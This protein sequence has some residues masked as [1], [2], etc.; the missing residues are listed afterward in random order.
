VHRVYSAVL[1]IWLSASVAV[2]QPPTIGNCTVFPAD[3]I[4]NTPVDQLPVSPTSSTYINTI[5]SKVG[6]HADFGSGLWAGGPIGI[7]YITVP[8]TQTKYP[9]T[10]LYADESDPGPYAIPLNAPI[11]GGSQSTGDRHTLAIDIDNCILYELGRAFPQTS[12][13]QADAGAIFNLLS[14]AL[15]PATWTSTDAAGLPLFAGLAR[16]DEIAAGAIRHALRFTVPKTQ[17]AYI[18]PARHYASS[19]TDTSYPPMGLRVRLRASYDISGFSA[20]NQIILRALKKYGMMLADNGSAWYISGA[21]DSRWDNDDLHQLGAIMGS[22]FEVVDVSSLMINAN[23]GQ[24]KQSGPSVITIGKTHSANF[25]QGQR[26]ATYNVTVSNAAGAGSTSSTVTVTET[27]P[28]G[29]TLVSMA[30]SG[31]SCPTGGNT[32]A[33]SDVLA[34]GTS[35]P[36]I[37]VTVNVASNATSPQVNSVTVSG[38]GSAGASA[39]DSTVIIPAMLAPVSVAPASGNLAQQTFVLRYSDTAGVGDLTTE[40]VWF[41]NSTASSTAG[42]CL[43]YYYRQAN[44]LYLLNDAGIAFQGPV[45]M[46]STNTLGNSQ[47][48]VNPAA[49]SV[50]TVSGTDLVVNLPVTFASTF[51]GSKNVKMHVEGL[52]G[53][54]SWVSMG[55]WTVPGTITVAPVSVTPS[56]G[57]GTQ[58]TFNLRYTDTAGV[59]DLTTEWVWFDNSTASNTTGTCLAYYYRQANTLY[60][61][62]DAGSAFLGPVTIG[63]ASTLSNS[64]CTLNAPTGSVSTPSGTDLVVNLPVTFASSFAG[65]KNVKMHVEGLSGQ[66]SWVPMGT[67]T[68]PGTITIAPVSVTPASGNLAQQTFALRYSDTAGVNDLTTEW[69]WFDNS[70]ASNTAGS[71]LAYY[72]RQANTL[73][74]L[75]DAGSAFLGPVTMGSASTLSNSQCTL[76]AAS[77]S[78]TT[79]SNTDLVVN[80][81]VSFASTFAGSKN[82]KMHVES[83]SGQSP[84]VAMGS[85]TVSGTITVAPVSVTPSSGS[86]AQQTFGLRYTDTAGV[87]DLTTEWV[88]FDNSLASSSAGSCLAYYYRQANTLYLLNDAGNAF[89]G[90][91]TMGSA[92]TLSNSQC[93]LNAAASSVSALSSTDFVVN[94]AVTFAPGF[95][96]SKNVKMHVESFS[97]QSAWAPIGSWTVQ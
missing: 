2:A 60:L 17:R 49:G 47:C 26:G 64:Q 80:L 33:R 9:A 23:S 4:W 3:N 1:L 76:N 18:W 46:G 8:G 68:I 48:T 82:V 83:L 19:I 50:S 36:A 97:G 79:L 13:W 21:P 65:S 41:D 39:T 11:E 10:F 20:A 74:L 61:L 72:Y 30:G 92:N 38:G 91:V 52:S 28:A 63:S 85:W 22:D 29:M 37:T 25:I 89:L 95:A 59:G 15:R 12:S 84:W 94:L 73:Y 51:A 55:T 42:T 78:L 87:G 35:Y 16:Y 32:C 96:G 69:V 70:S 77:S 81:A 93:T 43:A 27:L 53:Q 75:N 40:W 31:W 57:S 56:S 14:D 45:A 90:P 71:C 54:S 34:A 62:N 86:G 58:Q 88:W 24:A 7:P 66:S 67:W 6:V 5:G 44:T